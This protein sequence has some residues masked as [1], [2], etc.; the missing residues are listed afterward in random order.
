MAKTKSD[1]AYKALIAGS[2]THRID[3]IVRSVTEAGVTIDVKESGRI[4]RRATLIQMK[5]IVAHTG[6]GPGFV[7]ANGSYDLEPIAGTVVSE[8]ADGIT[9]KD[10]DGVEVTFPSN[11]ANGARFVSI[12]SDDRAL[13]KGSVETRINRLAERE[14]GG[15][16]PAKKS[17]GK[18]AAREEAKPAK[19]KKSGLRRKA[20]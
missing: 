6:E 15:S 13:N 4:V 2:G 7:V 12:A 16:K 3:G 8:D 10:A 17:A 14:E 1:A 9:I 5:D 18:K 19:S 20:K 11:G